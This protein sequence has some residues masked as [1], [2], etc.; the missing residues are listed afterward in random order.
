MSFIL[1]ACDEVEVWLHT[2]LGSA[3]DEDERFMPVRGG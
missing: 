3:L 1:K 2:F